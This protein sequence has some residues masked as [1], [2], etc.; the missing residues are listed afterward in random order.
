M[1]SLSIASTALAALLAVLPMRDAAAYY[2]HWHGDIHHFHDYDMGRWHSGYWHDGF[3]DGRNGWWWIVG[4]SWYYYPAP[5]YP[6]PD[7][8]VPSTVIV[9]QPQQSA[10]YW[11]C[12]N[13]EGYYPYVSACYMPWQP[14]AAQVMQPVT[15]PQ[16]VQSAAPENGT[17]DADDRQLN[18]LASEFY[19]IH[20]GSR[21]A[22]K[23]LS[24]LRK[25][26]EAFHETLFDRDYN[27]MD[28]LRDTE[29]LERRI[30]KKQ[31][32]AAGH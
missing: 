8:Y 25:R 29:K 2:G 30:A 15:V 24:D 21:G 13:P 26:V 3:H 16:P 28:I 23:R 14:V 31:K 20:S 11:Y 22:Q 7:P 17:R 4:G 27:A 19:A 1:K 18:A 6:Y 32:E 9:T 12:G 5:V 10:Q